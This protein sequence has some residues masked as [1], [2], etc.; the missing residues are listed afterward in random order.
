MGKQS[1]SKFSQA[2]PPK[3]QPADTGAGDNADRD[4]EA[5]RLGLAIEIAQR[6]PRLDPHRSALGI[7]TNAPNGPKVNN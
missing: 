2:W 1:D 4:D 5:E 7:N 3:R 6:D